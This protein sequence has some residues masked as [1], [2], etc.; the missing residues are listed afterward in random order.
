ML[1]YANMGFFLSLLRSGQALMLVS[2]ATLR[3]GLQK[4]FKTDHRGLWEILYS[5]ELAGNRNRA[6]LFSRVP[7]YTQ[8]RKKKCCLF[9]LLSGAKTYC[10][11]NFW[12]LEVYVLPS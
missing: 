3:P 7:A 8:A 1:L 5:H 10:P 4:L 6:L 12:E 2:P 9:P 11:G